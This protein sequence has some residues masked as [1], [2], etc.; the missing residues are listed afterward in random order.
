LSEFGG[1]GLKY[2]LSPPLEEAT[3]VVHRELFIS[4]N[5]HNLLTLVKP[6]SMGAARRVFLGLLLSGLRTWGFSNKSRI[7][8]GGGL[9]YELGRMAQIRLPPKIGIVLLLFGDSVRV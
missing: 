6:F 3:P 4:Q 8:F 1:V 7:I 9:I 2:P 5:S